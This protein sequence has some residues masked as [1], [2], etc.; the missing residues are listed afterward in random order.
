M[1]YFDWFPV[2]SVFLFV[3]IVVF[4]PWLV[5]VITIF[6]KLFPPKKKEELSAASPLPEKRSDYESVKHLIPPAPPAQKVAVADRF[7]SL[8]NINILLY[9]GTFLVVAAAG[10]FVG[11]NYETLSASFK[12]IFLF[13][14]TLVFYL[15][16]LFLYLKT[17]NIKP[18][19]I[20]FTTIG[21]LLAPLVGLAIYK[22]SYDGTNGQMI[23]FATSAVVL[24]F[25]VVTLAIIKQV[26]IGYLTSFTALSLFQS[27]IN[28]FDLPIYWSFW[29]MSILALI[30][31]LIVK[32]KKLPKI[33]A[34]PLDNTSQIFLP[35]SMAISASLIFSDGSSQFGLNI[36]LAGIFYLI[37]SF[38]YEE[39]DKS[40]NNFSL[41]L[42][43][44]PI[45]LFSILIQGHRV[46]YDIIASLLVGLSVVYLVVYEVVKKYW[47]NEKTNSLMAIGG[48]VAILAN[49][50]LIDDPKIL[51]FGLVLTI[52]I[53]L[54][55][56]VPAKLY[57]NLILALV[58]ILSLPY[59]VFAFWHVQNT[60]E[61]QSVCY[62]LIGVG[63]LLVKWLTN[64]TLES[65]NKGIL[66][67]SYWVAILITFILAS[68][69]HPWFMVGVGFALTVM[70][71]VASFVEG[72]GLILPIS[73]IFYIAA[74]N[75]ICNTFLVGREFYPLV[76][77]GGALII[78]A[79]SFLLDEKRNKV[80]SY[81]ALIPAFW[82]VFYYL[83][84]D[85]QGSAWPILSL[86]LTG[87][88]TS[89]V[90]YRYKN[91]TGQAIG[92]AVMLVAVNWYLKFLGEE[93]TQ[94]YMLIWTAYFAV[95]AYLSHLQ[96]KRSNQDL[97]TIAALGF[98]IIPLLFQAMGDESQWYGLMLGIEGILLILVGIASHYKL[99]R[100]WG[101]VALVIIV[102]EQMRDYLLEIPQWII[103][104]GVGMALLAGA[105]VLLARR[106]E[107]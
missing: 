86:F 103:I 106:K 53:N 10:I 90:Y 82:G 28:L 91:F 18:A 6:S 1:D 77:L 83:V 58:G 87:G 41:S 30:F 105:I 81:T 42:L 44:F 20:T 96:K 74:L 51:I 73:M 68:G 45:G 8:E 23:W 59:S 94:V 15:A 36:L 95:L 60:P 3:L 12:V 107:E 69:H 35:V 27:S 39:E 37:K 61:V 13:I 88:L 4:V 63:I 80:L 65:Q 2:G 57:F 92:A 66:S 9:V 38:L 24:A 16:G 100:T 49:L 101:I 17:K 31:A 89:A 50:L 33:I 47:N 72:I 52:L 26:Y 56:F 14:F 55:F 98:L 93:E 75:Q 5:G 29:G 43:L 21:L 99:I 71:F 78:V 64:K 25:Y 11:F 22:F 7:K 85:S 40:T 102:L 32:V 67:I 76:M 46:D 79:I 104:G 19:G 34:D 70:V 97:F 84:R 54:Y 48:L 62:L